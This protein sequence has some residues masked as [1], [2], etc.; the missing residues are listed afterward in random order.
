MK[1]SHETTAGSVSFQCKH[2]HANCGANLPVSRFVASRSYAVRYSLSVAAG[3]SAVLG[4]PGGYVTPLRLLQLASRK[5]CRGIK[6]PYKSGVLISN[7][8]LVFLRTF[9]RS[10][11][12]KGIRG[13][14]A[15]RSLK[16]LSSR[17]MV[18]YA[19]PDTVSISA[20]PQSPM[21]IG[22]LLV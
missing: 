20:L 6:Q 19:S 11:S 16:C 1:E 21:V 14:L 8:S 17:C 9:S 13:F 7:P 4:W 12:S 2:S 10:P 5:G 3:I 18:R 15:T 22:L